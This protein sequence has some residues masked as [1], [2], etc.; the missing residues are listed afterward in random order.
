MKTMN[1]K[2]WYNY[3]TILLFVALAL[4][5]QAQNVTVKPSSGAMIASV[6]EDI[7][8]GNDDYDTFYRRGGFATWRHNQLCLTMTAS[9]VKTLTDNGQLANPANNLYG[10]TSTNEIEL[11]R[12]ANN[13]TR[14]SYMN[15]ALPKGYRFTGY[16][17]VFSRNRSDFGND[18]YSNNAN[19]GGTTRFGETDENFNYKEG[20]Y[21]DITYDASATL[22]EGSETI[23]KE[24]AD[25]MSNVLYFKLTDANTG[26]G[27][28][29]VTFHSITLYFTA[30]D[31][32]TPVMPQATID[33][34]VTAVD[35][36]FATGKVDYGSIESRYYNGQSRVSYSSAN[37][38]DMTANMV[39]Y[40]AESIEDGTNFD[41]TTGKI[42]KYE[43]GGTIYNYQDFFKLGREDQE[44][45]YF[46]ETPTYVTLPD[47]DQTKNPVG[48]R[49]VAAEL[50]YQYGTAL[51]ASQVTRT[52]YYI[53]YTTG[54]NTYYL[55]TSGNF[56]QGTKTEWF[57]DDNNRIYS[58]N[59]Y[60]G[61]TVSG[62]GGNRTYTF[63]TFT[64]V[65]TNPLYAYNG[66]VRGVYSGMMN[67]YYPYLIGSTSSATLS[68][69]DTNRASWTTE[70]ETIDLPA[71]TPAPFKL[72]VYGKDGTELRTINVNS[73]ADNN[74]VTLTGLNN[75][76]IK[77]GVEGIGFV[78]GTLTMQALDPYIDRM[79]V[80]CQDMDQTAIRM[81]QPFESNDFEM[82]GDEFYFFLPSDCVGHTVKITYE[83]LWSH[84]ADES[85]EGGS[86]EHTSRFN[87]VNSAHYNKFTSDNIYN[88]IAEAAAGKTTVSERQKVESVGSKKFRFNN[89][90]EMTGTGG[91]LTEYPFTKANYAAAPNN[92][93]FYTMEYTVSAADQEKTAYV[94]TTDETRYN[95]APTTAVQHRTYAFYEMIVHVQSAT[96]DPKV[97]FEKIYDASFYDNDGS[98]NGAT[99]SF[100][101]AIITAPYGT[102]VQQGFASD[103]EIQEVINDAITVG[104]D[105]FNHT[106]VPT[107]ANQI[108]Y[109]DMSQLA[110][111]YQNSQAAM[112][113]N[114]Y[115]QTLAKNA[116]MFLPTNATETADN[117]A[118]MTAGSNS[119]AAQ[120]IVITDKNPFFTPYNIQVA[121]QNYATYTR[122]ITKSSYDDEVYATVIMPFIV[123]LEN[124][125]HDDDNGKFEFLQMN[126]TAATSDN[127]YNYG[128][129]FFS[130][131]SA[132]QTEANTPYA[133]HVLNS[134]NSEGS[135]TLSQAG[136]SI[137]ATP[138]A[139]KTGNTLF[140]A[141]E[142]TSTGN[143]TDKDGVS[144]T[145]TFSH[146]GSFS[147]YKIP[148]GNPKT[149][150]F[151][152]NGF[153]S[154]AE[155]N[156]R[157]TTVDL[158]PFRSVYEVTSGGSAK[159]GFLRLVEGQNE[160]DGIS[161]TSY[162]GN[163][164]E[165]AA[166]YDMQ[167]RMIAPRMSDLKGR[168][169][170]RGVYVVN[171]VK[172]IV[173]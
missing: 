143:L 132:A 128:V 149:F 79:K 15:L 139:A 159:V 154:S 101:G 8:G 152:N 136:A 147:G 28:M 41:G 65:P 42:V 105:D 130:K 127:A 31:D 109:V 146:K 66:Y 26:T 23:S 33:V 89:A 140:S 126:T 4:P 99:G 35:V 100:Y 172:I 17:I 59:I 108:L 12:G 47:E 165:N 37:V 27:R 158:Y 5:T 73:S 6:P 90:D 24:D 171:G 111:Y 39:L 138:D 3:V 118:S 62:N 91:T 169:L 32:Y 123:K 7:G 167:G 46:I 71:F 56:V 45:V 9:D 113:M 54:G 53:T 52:H 129:A 92:G 170:D 63:T 98:N 36:P 104:H 107:N 50:E 84:Y 97:E 116:L 141:N 40:E 30:E 51:P 133:L 157:Y 163:V 131:T 87:F 160:T 67:T 134:R 114:A 61:Y 58:G 10:R 115:R 144:S 121:S 124:G 88:D 83:D 49:I 77:F 72:H 55:N 60:L 76:A 156:S 110:G 86:S 25:G 78:K 125:V 14:N 106:D 29:V 38:V 13:D 16:E 137:I 150:Y 81:S 153:Y 22:D 135:F 75:D 162:E 161:A 70:S 117:F 173:K 103:K 80:V 168:K 122:T 19:T 18:G 119:R 96:Y 69:S 11:G 142:L 112:S 166:V 85:Y 2:K 82:N 34:P 102:P 43:E 68:T 120:N 64:S 48:Y 57:L 93:S 44:Q 21:K 1:L 94:F 145:Y 148:K 155:L 74:K 95:I 151:A 164:D 20:Y